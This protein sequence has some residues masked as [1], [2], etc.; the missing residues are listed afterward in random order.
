MPEPLAPQPPGPTHLPDSTHSAHI[1]LSSIGDKQ[2]LISYMIK[3][4]H[5]FGEFISFPSYHGR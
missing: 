1:D 4:H 3:E 5:T 2:P